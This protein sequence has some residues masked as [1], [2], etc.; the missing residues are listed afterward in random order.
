MVAFT[1]S[2]A[3]NYTFCNVNHCFSQSRETECEI[4]GRTEWDY[5]LALQLLRDVKC[6]EHYFSI[7]VP[8]CKISGN[9]VSGQRNWVS[10][11]VL[12]PR[13]SEAE[14]NLKLWAK[15]AQLKKSYVVSLQ[16]CSTGKCWVSQTDWWINELV[17]DTNEHIDMDITNTHTRDRER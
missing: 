10:A 15:P 14:R 4:T 13:C 16:K 2:V 3:Y 6:L 7:V 5:V 12:C 17:N 1:V 8:F 11:Q 9:G